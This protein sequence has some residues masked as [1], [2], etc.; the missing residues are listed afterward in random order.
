ML[1][2]P[3]KSID[4]MPA[5][6]VGGEALELVENMRLLGVTI[7][8]DLKWSKNTADVVKRACSKL[9]IL[10]RLKGLGAQVPELLDI[11]FKHC[12]SILEFAVPVWQSSITVEERESLEKVQKI[13][14]HIILGERYCSY[15]KALQT[16]GL[17]TLENRR[18]KICLKFA[19][20]AE[21]NS[22]YEQ[23]F[24]RKPKMGTRQDPVKYWNPVTRTTRLKNSPICYLTRLLNTH[25]QT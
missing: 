15:R 10:R 17:E 7:S 4:F 3:C 12:R 2:N 18:V 19:R 20:K 16:T 25:Y 6:E 24:K 11:Y 14:L 23:W 22:K 9:W 5:L 1:F 13:A 21:I 8:S